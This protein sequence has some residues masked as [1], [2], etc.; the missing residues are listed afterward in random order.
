MKHKKLK[1]AICV[2]III[3]ILIIAK[4]S[5]NSSK[6][7]LLSIKTERE[8]EKKYNNNSN[9]ILDVAKQ[10]VALPWSIVSGINKSVAS[11]RPSSGLRRSYEFNRHAFR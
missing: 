1:I 6:V 8:L 11:T 2:V 9:E 10:I 7:E 5:F 4:I 3:I